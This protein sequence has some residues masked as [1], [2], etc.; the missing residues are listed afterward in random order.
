[1]TANYVALR[2]SQTLEGRD[3]VLLSERGCPMPPM[4]LTHHRAWYQEPHA[5]GLGWS[6]PAA[7][8]MQLAEPDLHD[9]LKKAGLLTRDAR[10]VEHRFQTAPR[11][12]LTEHGLAA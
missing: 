5:G 11:F 9:P 4:T 12:F 3:A 2:V 1:M 10:M 8:G 6:F 7:L